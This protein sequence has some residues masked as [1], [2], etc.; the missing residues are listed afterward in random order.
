M[1]VKKYEKNI[2]YDNNT[3]ANNKYDFIGNSR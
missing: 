2:E 1:D 3:I